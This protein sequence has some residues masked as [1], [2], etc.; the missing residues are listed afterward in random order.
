MLDDV[1]S[2]VNVRGW[3]CLA[4]FPGIFHVETGFLY[5]SAYLFSYGDIFPIFN[6][7]DCQHKK[8]FY[9]LIKIIFKNHFN[10]VNITLGDWAIEHTNCIDGIY[11]NLKSFVSFP[12]IL[13]N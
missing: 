11:I 2:V 8:E 10:S 9:T 13:A 7:G 3:I 12:T 6:I 1:V 5:N 4:H